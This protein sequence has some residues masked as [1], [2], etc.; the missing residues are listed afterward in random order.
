MSN[1]H[2]LEVVARG[3]ETQL[4]VVGNLKYLIDSHAFIL[5]NLCHN[6]PK[7]HDICLPPIINLFQENHK[8]NDILDAPPFNIDC[9]LDTHLT[10]HTIIP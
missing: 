2:P 10:T 5:S 8:A 6:F 9:Y 3:S 4:Q 1:F 7:N